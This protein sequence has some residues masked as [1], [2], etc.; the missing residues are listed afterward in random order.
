MVSTGVRNGAVVTMAGSLGST[1]VG[2][3]ARA[4]SVV[5]GLILCAL[6]PHVYTLE[7]LDDLLWTAKTFAAYV[8]YVDCT[9]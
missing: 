2:L 5:C 1:F 6:R 8:Y 7:S 3:Y 9:S 4:M